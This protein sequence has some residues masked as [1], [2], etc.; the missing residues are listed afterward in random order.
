M[1]VLVS[2]QRLKVTRVCSLSWDVFD[3]DELCYWQKPRPQFP[4]NSLVSPLVVGGWVVSGSANRRPDTAFSQTWMGTCKFR[5]WWPWWH[6]LKV[7]HRMKGCPMAAHRW[8]LSKGSLF[9]SRKMGM[10][11][12][13]PKLFDSQ[14]TT[15]GVPLAS[16][17]YAAK[18]LWYATGDKL[19]RICDCKIWIDDAVGNLQ[20]S[21]LENESKLAQGVHSIFQS[22]FV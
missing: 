5:S 20:I 11:D 21:G 8:G 13:Q 14:M 7:S 22:S 16:S 2:K 6:L 4:V 1:V 3:F 15:L 10:A 19:M 12:D 18:C 17:D 9:L